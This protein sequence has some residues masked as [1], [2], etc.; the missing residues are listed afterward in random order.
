MKLRYNYTYNYNYTFESLRKALFQ[1]T[2][3]TALN[4]LI[5]FF[6]KQLLTLRQKCPNLEFAGLYFPVFGLI[7]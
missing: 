4:S 6:Q 5:L 1:N 7:T 3:D 2:S